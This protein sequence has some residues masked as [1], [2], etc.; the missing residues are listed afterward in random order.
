MPFQHSRAL[1]HIQVY[2]DE[3]VK[4]RKAVVMTRMTRTWTV[5]TVSRKSINS[6]TENHHECTPR[7]VATL[8]LTLGQN[9]LVLYKTMTRSRHD[10]FTT[11]TPV[12]IC[13]WPI[14][15]GPRRFVFVLVFISNLLCNH[16]SYFYQ[17]ML[18]L[19]FIQILL[20]QLYWPIIFV[21]L[22]VS[23][24]IIFLVTL[25]LLRSALQLLV[26]LLLH[27]SHSHSVDSNYLY[28]RFLHTCCTC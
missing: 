20:T 22:E 9:T 13:S 15:D 3:L 17:S 8:L 16:S 5:T 14:Y 24:K 27:H 2:K 21:Y 26:T 19:H 18:F 25:L 6:S 4:A 23:S 28:T 7:P 1:E 11:D 10:I 12:P